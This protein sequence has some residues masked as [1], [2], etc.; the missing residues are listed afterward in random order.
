[1]NNDPARLLILGTGNMANTHVKAFAE[2]DGVDVVA[3]VDTDHDRLNG[4]C[5]AHNIQNR[6][7]SLDA[8]LSWGEF[9][10][11]SNVT[12]DRIHHPTTMQLAAAGKHILC[13]KPLADNFPNALEMANAASQAG[14]V[15][16][17]NL[18]YR[19]LASMQEARRLVAAGKVGT[20]RH[21]EASYLQS[22]L[23]QPLWGDWK[24]DPTWLWRLSSAHGSGG[25]LGDIGIHILDYTTFVIGSDAESVSCRLKTFSKI[26]GDAIGEFVLD[27]NDS[28]T[29][30]LE[31]GQGAIGVVHATRFASGH[32]NDLRLRIW[33]DRGGL[34]VSLEGK[35]EKLRL[36][37]SADLENPVWR[38]V[39]FPPTCSI[40]R[41][42]AAALHGEKEV[43]P[44]FTRGAA[45]QEMLDLAAQSDLK[46]G[47]VLE[48]GDSRTMYRGS[49]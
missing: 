34:E 20:V 28:F 45:L 26:P 17:I 48:R 38:D 39:A 29:M 25:V 13:E 37:A 2:I 9:D 33:G 15:N 32:I 31:L 3:A 7:Q 42:F 4:F 6:F 1:M 18:S 35:K 22:W 8:A 5:D 49:L 44:D 30:Q 36:C 12:P 27:A 14:I 40:Y 16:M 47:L 41:Q 23:T 21:F 10:A 46:N 24:T 43:A 11:V 19:D